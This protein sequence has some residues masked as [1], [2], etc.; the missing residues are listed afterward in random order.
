MLR[1]MKIKTEQLIEF[2][3]RNQRTLDEMDNLKMKLQEQAKEITEM[4]LKTD[5]LVSTNDGLMAEKEHMTIELRETRDLQKSY[6]VKCT[7]LIQK[8]NNTNHEFHTLKKKMIG[9]D[10]L[11]KEKMPESR[12]SRTSMTR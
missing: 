3:T 11:A 5:V 12:S 8:L 1:E 9:H 4:K 6:E 10:E 2:E 7:D